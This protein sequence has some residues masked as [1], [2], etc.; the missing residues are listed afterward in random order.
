VLEGNAEVARRHFS[1][2]AL[3]GQLADLLEAAGWDRLL[4]DQG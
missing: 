1:M 4:A 3:S 2:D